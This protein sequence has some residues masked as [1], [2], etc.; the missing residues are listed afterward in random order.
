LPGL[1]NGSIPPILLLKEIST[2]LFS[3]AKFA[4]TD[5]ILKEASGWIST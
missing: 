2:D 5:L 1:L 4:E 3:V